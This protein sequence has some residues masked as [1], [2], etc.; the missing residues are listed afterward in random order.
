MTS[1]ALCRAL[2]RIPRL[3]TAIAVAVA[4]AST[5]RPAGALP[6]YLTAFEAQYPAAAGTRIDSCNLCHTTVPALNPYGAAFA[7]SGHEFAPI[8]EADSDGDGFSNLAEI[9]ALTFPGNAE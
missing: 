7:A 6:A 8:E 2:N 3:V 1:T 5:A 9:E 4:L